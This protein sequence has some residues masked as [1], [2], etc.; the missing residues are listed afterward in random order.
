[1]RLQ[2]FVLYPGYVR[3]VEKREKKG[4]PKWILDMGRPE[5]DTRAMTRRA[6]ARERDERDDESDDDSPVLASNKAVF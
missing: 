1:M 6:R 4:G 3:T 2:L 5:S